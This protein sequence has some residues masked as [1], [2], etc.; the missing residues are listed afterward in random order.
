MQ[1]DGK[2]CISYNLKQQC[3]VANLDSKLEKSLLSEDEMNSKINL[4]KGIKNKSQS[5]NAI[6]QNANIKKKRLH[7]SQMPKHDLDSSSNH[8]ELGP[9][10]NNVCISNIYSKEEIQKLRV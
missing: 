1:A 3:Q 6:A 4:I 8:P 9:M 7:M 10:I 5:S 2:H